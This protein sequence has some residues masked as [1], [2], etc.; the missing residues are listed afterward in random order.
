MNRTAFGLASIVCGTAIAGTLDA[1]QVYGTPGSP[2]AR[3]TMPGDQLPPRPQKFGRVIGVT[4]QQSKP[5]RP[6]RIVPPKGAPNA[7]LMMS[8]YVGVL[9][10]RPPI[11]GG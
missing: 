11:A 4:A 3:T 9:A 2:G 10:V 7:L 8:E 5:Y 1:Q 6:A